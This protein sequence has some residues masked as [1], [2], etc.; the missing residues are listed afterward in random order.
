MLSFFSKFK[1]IYLWM[2]ADQAG[3]IASESFAKVKII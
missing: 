1:K 3:K 2:D